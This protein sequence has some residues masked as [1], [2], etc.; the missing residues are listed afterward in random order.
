MSRVIVDDF[1]L[2]GEWV[3]V[4]RRV[5]AEGGG[6]NV[7]HQFQCFWIRTLVHTNL[8]LYEYFRAP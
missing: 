3:R 7:T 6:F 1:T 4:K 8:L 5:G 2:S